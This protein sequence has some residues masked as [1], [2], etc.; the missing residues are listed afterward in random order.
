M[1]VV[2]LQ[3]LLGDHVTCPHGYHVCSNYRPC[4]EMASESPTVITTPYFNMEISLYSSSLFA[5]MYISG[6][7]GTSADTG[8]YIYIQSRSPFF[9]AQSDT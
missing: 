5:C 9:A 1:E 6:L 7:T 2:Y 8:A 3:S 4:V